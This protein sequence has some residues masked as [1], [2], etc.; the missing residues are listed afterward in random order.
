MLPQRKIPFG[1]TRN[2][3]PL[4]EYPLKKKYESGIIIL[5][6]DP[7]LVAEYEAREAAIYCHY[8]YTE[9]LELHPWERAKC[10]AQYREHYRIEANMND[11]AETAA[12]RNRG[13]D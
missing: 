5:S 12:Q 13:R 4:K 11:A 9:F 3:T 8:N 7:S 2:G 10:V 1:I 6:D